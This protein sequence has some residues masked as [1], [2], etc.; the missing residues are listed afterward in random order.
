MVY[1]DEVTNLCHLFS[2]GFGVEWG[3]GEEYMVLF[4]GYTQLF[5]SVMPDLLH[6]VPVGDDTAFNGV[7]EAIFISLTLGFITD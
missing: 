4:W 3:L 7:T 2:V 5:E 6:I 1:L